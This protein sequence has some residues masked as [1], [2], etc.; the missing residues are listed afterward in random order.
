MPAHPQAS[1]HNSLLAAAPIHTTN[2]AT[3][4][5][6]STAQLTLC[7]PDQEEIEEDQLQRALAVNA[8][9]QSQRVRKESLLAPKA[10]DTFALSYAEQLA[11]PSTEVT[12][13]IDSAK[14]MS[15]LLNSVHV[16]ASL[17]MLK[18]I[19]PTLST[20][21]ESFFSKYK[22]MDVYRVMS[23]VTD[24]GDQKDCI[25]IDM[26]VHKVKVKAIIDSG[27]PGNIVSSRLVKKLK[28]APD[29]GYQEVFGTEGPL[30]TKAMSAYSS[31]PLWFGKLIVAA[32]AI[33]L[34]N[35]SYYILIGT[36]FMNKYGFI[37]NHGD[38]TFKILGQTIPIY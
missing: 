8:L 9:T 23:L 21:L 31:L 14:K 17:E 37:K 30:T 5:S 33:V 12:N 3:R 16:S 38:D 24:K 22:D 28:L 13:E 2:S 15:Q 19:S 25:Y 34:E 36:G 20:A 32:P 11:L 4:L 6:D 7:Y 35:S 1:D 26:V 10:Q 27:A 18:G 29:L